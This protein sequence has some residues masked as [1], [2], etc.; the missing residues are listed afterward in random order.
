MR[1]V[2]ITLKTIVITILSVFSIISAFSISLVVSSFVEI[3]NADESFVNIEYYNQELNL[4]MPVNGT[5]EKEYLI[6]EG[7]EFISYSVYKMDDYTS[8]LLFTETGF[9]ETKEYECCINSIKTKID[10]Q[11][12]FNYQHDFNSKNGYVVKY[13]NPRVNYEYFLIYDYYDYN[14]YIIYKW[15]S[16]EYHT[17]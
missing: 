1:I 7:Y 14:L 9:E 4:N 6:K 16:K 15:N 10:E 12:D 5:F 11:H 3:L 17:V 2:A 8:Y 13:I